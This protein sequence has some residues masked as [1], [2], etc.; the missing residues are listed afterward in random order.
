MKKLRLIVTLALFIPLI[1]AAQTSKNAVKE[2]KTD[3]IEA[4]YFHFTARCV[5]CRTVEEQTKNSIQ[6]LYPALVKE[7]KITFRAVNLDET[8]GKTL[9]EKMKISGQTVLIVKGE[10]KINLTNEGFLYAVSNPDKYK[11]I[12]KE[13]I[14]RLLEL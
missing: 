7:G 8:E 2:A 12:I 1:T 4:W 14:D 6:T 5:T 13:K 10:Q 11:S 3:Q 9:G